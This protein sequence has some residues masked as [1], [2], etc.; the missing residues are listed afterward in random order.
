MKLNSMKKHDIQHSLIVV[1]EA[2]KKE[3]GSTVSHKY[4]DGEQ[5]LGGI[6][7]YISEELMK[8]IEAMK[9]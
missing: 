9:D 1:A 6:G 5:R 8:K 3:D 7:D 4:I 2:V